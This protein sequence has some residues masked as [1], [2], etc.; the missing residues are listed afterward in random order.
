M[1]IPGTSYPLGTPHAMDI[2]FKFNNEVPPADGTSGNSYFGGKRPDR[3]IASHHMAE[4][5]TTFAR[6]GIPAATGVPGW[7]AYNFRNRPTMRIDSKCEVLNNRYAEEL[8]MWREIGRMLGNWH[9]SAI[10]MMMR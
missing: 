3:F 4:L 6:T 5:W 9:V 8:N 7:P 10:L 2:T 1:L